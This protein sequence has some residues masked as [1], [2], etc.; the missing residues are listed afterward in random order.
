MYTYVPFGLTLILLCFS[1]VYT[2]KW[3]KKRQLKNKQT[4]IA[5]WQKQQR[6]KIYT[7]KMQKKGELNGG[8]D[9]RYDVYVCVCVC[10]IRGHCLFNKNP[11]WPI[12]FRL[13]FFSC[14]KRVHK[15]LI[16]NIQIC[17]LLFCVFFSF[18]IHMCGRMNV[19]VCVC[20]IVGSI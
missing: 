18:S 17:W 20:V 7:K 11:F 13:T 3:K 12:H 6:K 4:T 2:W 9:W 10:T 15:R 19:C 8:K 5:I 16:L 14:N 1:T